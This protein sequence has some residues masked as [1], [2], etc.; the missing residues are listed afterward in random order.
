MSDE[1]N[2]TVVLVTGAGSGIGQATAR[3]FA[4]RGAS[5]VVNDIRPEAGEETVDQI[6]AAGGTASFHCADVADAAAVREMIDACVAAHGR[7]DCAFNNAGM[8]GVPAKTADCAEEDWYRE[9]GVMIHGV[10]HCLKYE[11]RQMLRQGSGRIVSTASIAGLVGYEG[12]SPSLSASKFAVIGMTK[13]AALEYAKENIR[14]NAVCPG[15]TLSQQL[16]GIFERHPEYAAAT[17]ALHP[18]GR[19]AQPREIA[20]AVAWLCSDAASFVTGHAMVVD[21]A[22]TAQ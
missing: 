12:V 16:T 5:V 8:G 18:I 1:F 10:F 20:E 3:L 15:A 19:M 11:I 13:T 14:I 2:N 6:R 21:G 22:Y 7:I 9:T 4:E 17:E